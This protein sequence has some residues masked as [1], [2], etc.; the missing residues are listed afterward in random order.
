MISVPFVDDIFFWSTDVKFV[1]VLEIQLRKQ[2][3]LLEGKYNAVDSLGSMCRI[4]HTEGVPRLG[5]VRS[6]RPAP[7]VYS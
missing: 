6:V 4:R 3:L 7:P 1:I 5:Y 2:G